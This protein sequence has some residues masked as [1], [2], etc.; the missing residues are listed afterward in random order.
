MNNDNQCI[1]VVD[2]EE[3][4]IQLLSCYFK[5]ANYELIIARTGKEALDIMQKSHPDL[6]L[7]DIQMPGLNGI[8]VLRVAKSIGSIKDIP[9]IM[10]TASC[11]TDYMTKSLELGAT[12][13]FTRPINFE[14]L[15]DE[16]SKAIGTSYT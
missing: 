8:E 2:D 3:L 4:N 1:L 14:I 12:A 15:M 5:G 13:F 10:L 9:I 6:V 16:I 11:K 7:L